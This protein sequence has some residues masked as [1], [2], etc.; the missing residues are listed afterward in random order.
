MSR[1]IAIAGALVLAGWDEAPRRGSVLV[2]GGAIAGV[3]HGDDARDLE[4]RA[5]ERVDAGGLVLM[6][7]LVNAHHHAYGNAL[8]G[9]ENA[10]PLEL[11]A[12]FTVAWGRA[13]DAA[14][15]RLAILL[16][17]AEMLRAGV[18]SVID[19]S[20]PLSLAEASF[21]AHVESGMR[22]GFAPFL[23]DRH[24]HDLLGL[25]LPDDLRAALEGAGFAS[26][27]AIEAK[28]RALAAAAKESDGRV[29]LLVGPNAPQRC[30][31]VLLDLWARLA[32]R[33]DLGAHTHLL[34]TR[35]QAEIGRRLHHGSLVAML[36]ERGLLNGRLAV[37]HGVWLK[38]AE[39]ALLARRGVTVVH[40]P[41]SNL[42]LGSGTMPWASYTGL[43][44][45]LALGSDSANT[46]GSANP[47][48]L[49]RL[50]LMLPRVASTDW[51]RW[52]TP[53]DALRMATEGGAAALGLAGRTG[54][55]APGFAADLTL[56]AP[57]CAIVPS[58]EALVQHG[59]PHAVRATMVAG[60][61]AYRDGRVLAFDEMAVEA[62][63]HD[64]AGEIAERAAPALAAARVARDVLGPQL[65]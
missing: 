49:M 27:D 13:L 3:A 9:T 37:A 46:G 38:P 63:F 28:Y 59:G 62:A 8:R 30:S 26:A 42:M 64:R 33:H 34:E 17:A 31:P 65:G 15:L 7:A 12:P 32:E 55:I 20:P 58:V 57:A 56:V 41:A 47:F 48:E 50:A 22:V 4:A 24:D 36:D 39:R 21:A 6:P 61:W 5:A 54:R 40:N 29:R 14:T 44:A 60:R 43:G 11:W 51:R 25:T 52:P 23:H 53:R 18:A 16:G 1:P 35:A 10:L 2:E 45:T 19:H